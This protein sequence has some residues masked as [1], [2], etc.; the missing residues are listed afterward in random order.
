[1]G[2]SLAGKTWQRQA[3]RLFP[4]LTKR[5]RLRLQYHAQGDT[6]TIPQT[7]D[8]VGYV[9]SFRCRPRRMRRHVAGTATPPSI[10]T[11]SVT[12]T[13][14][15]R[16]ARISALDRASNSSQEFVNLEREGR[17]GRR[18]G[19]LRARGGRRA[20]SRSC[21]FHPG[22]YLRTSLPGE[23]LDMGHVMQKYREEADS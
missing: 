15:S 16:S 5:C 22:G 4:L 11:T 9:S 6:L 18:G 23:L 1:M 19:A 17:T 8:H 12:S 7:S 10:A 2:T 3:L 20:K 13:K 14:L 21:H